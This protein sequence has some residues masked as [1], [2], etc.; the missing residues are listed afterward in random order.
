MIM[1]Q[2]S[3]SPGKYTD[4]QNCGLVENGGKTPLAIERARISD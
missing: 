4:G 2:S 3:H 1:L